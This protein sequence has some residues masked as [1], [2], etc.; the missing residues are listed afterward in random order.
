LRLHAAALL[1]L[2]TLTPRA[3]VA[4]PAGAAEV[5]LEVWDGERFAVVLQLDGA[6]ET[7]VVPLS[8]TVDVLACAALTARGVRLRASGATLTPEALEVRRVEHAVDQRVLRLDGEWVLAGPPRLP[9][10]VEPRGDR[11]LHRPDLLARLARQDG[12]GV[13]PGE[14]EV[15]L[16]DGIDED[17]L[18]PVAI[19]L[20]PSADRHPHRRRRSAS[21][22]ALR[23]A[24]LDGR[25]RLRSERAL[26]A[27]QLVRVEP[28]EPAGAAALPVRESDLEGELSV[29]LP[30]PGDVGRTATLLIRVDPAQIGRAPAAPAE[31]ER[32]GPGLLHDVAPELGLD[33]VHLEGPHEQL[34]IRP[35]MGPGAAWG[36]LDDD[37][38][39]DL[40][41]VAGGGRPGSAP[42][43][44][45]L[46]LARGAR[47]FEDVTERAGL[48]AAG[49]GMGAQ[50]VDLDGDGALDL[51]IANYGPDAVHAHGGLDGRGLPVL[52]E[53][54]DAAGLVGDRWS[55]GVAAADVDRDG[56]LDLY[57]TGYLLYDESLMPPLE[58]LPL[59]REDPIEML[60]FAFPGERNVLWE[61]VSAPGAIRLQ[62]STDRFALADPEGRGMQPA[63]FDFD[64]DGT[65]DLYVAN[66]VS[67]N[68]LY[69]V[70]AEGRFADIAFQTGMDDP[71]GGMGVAIGDVDGDLD[72][73]LFLTNWELEPNALYRNNV[74]SHSSRRR[75]V[76]SFR[77]VTVQ[78]G[79]GTHGVGYTSWGAELFDLEL[80]G[81]LDLFVANGYTSPDYESTGICVGQP[82]HLYIGD[83]E[84]H[85]RLDTDLAG[86]DLAVEHASRTVAACDYDRDGDVDLL[87]TANNG[88]VQL[89][90]NRAPRP[91]D[92]RWLGLSLRGRAPN[93]FAIGARVTVSIDGREFTRTL[94]AGT[95]YLAGNPPELHFGLG[96]L[97]GEAEVRVHW[98]TG[99]TSEH[100]AGLESR[101]LTLEEP[102]Q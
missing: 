50:F 5:L 79:F 35:T 45:R 64:V 52:R 39:P 7:A 22:E 43:E 88:P 55:A 4:S 25:A 17:H 18:E 26:D 24:H 66:D 53:V 67:P 93:R 51:F 1:T 28:F 14:F 87:V 102:S 60:P 95:S 83:G 76:A 49:H 82:N 13:A 99:V 57:V 23:V 6:V 81:D 31:F 56:D 101:W 96:A 92:A 68:R 32:V 44:G 89:L 41:L 9:V 46:L 100:A 85:F 94:R 70:G 74:R 84:G 36:D 19:P 10:R 15:V 72:E 11:S 16:P 34:D 80:D 61:N 48:R 33:L 91:D 78:S 54:S 62:D 47:D 98:P 2:L 90:E 20:D 97:R 30:A 58:D 29:A 42:P 77:D 73:D 3:T 21:V 59:S 40:F 12:L 86:P 71:R 37:G 38:R 63:F 69:R 27:L 75:H 65:Q 8:T